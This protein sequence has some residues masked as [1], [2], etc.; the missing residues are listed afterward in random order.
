VF[1]PH[2]RAFRLFGGAC[3]R[4]IYDNMK[5]AVDAVFVGKE[6]RFNRRFEQ[7]CSHYLVEPVACTPAA[8]WEKGQVEN[9]VGNA[10]ER[11]F[12]PRLRFAGY[13]E[14]NAWLADACVAHA[15]EAPHPEQKDRS[16]WSMFEAERAS[17]TPIPAASNA[18][19]GIAG[20]IG[21]INQIST[22][23]ATDVDQQGDATRGIAGTVQQ[24]AGGATAVSQTVESLRE[25]AAANGSSA[26]AMRDST[27][28][29]AELAAA[30][31]GEVSAFLEHVRAA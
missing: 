19:A 29:L 15:R 7:M 1:D 21:E 26:D 20:T 3:R 25:S 17:L 6:R 11:F 23:I 18:I 14:L 8:G 24:V 10:R 28:R 27:R 4:G 2:D 5:T 31:R 13:G 16:V 30:P 22:A 9:Q 12:T